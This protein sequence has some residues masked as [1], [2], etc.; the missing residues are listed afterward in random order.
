MLRRER[1]GMGNERGMGRLRR[2][3]EGRKEKG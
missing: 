2:E 3:I 1:G